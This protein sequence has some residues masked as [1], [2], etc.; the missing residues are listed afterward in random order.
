MEKKDSILFLSDKWI[1]FARAFFTIRV[2][3]YMVTLASLPQAPRLQLWFMILIE[4]VQLSL[5]IRNIFEHG[6]TS[7]WL[8]LIG[9]LIGISLF[10]SL[11][12][13]ALVMIGIQ[14]RIKNST[15]MLQKNGYYLILTIFTVEATLLVLSLIFSGIKQI[16]KKKSKKGEKKDLASKKNKT[17]KKNEDLVY[18]WVQT[19][20]LKNF[21]DEQVL[22]LPIQANPKARANSGSIMKMTRAEIHSNRMIEKKD[23]KYQYLSS[24]E[25]YEYSK[26]KVR[27]LS[28][29]SINSS[30]F[31]VLDIKH[32]RRKREKEDNLDEYLRQIYF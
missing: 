2:F 27:E 20:A 15:L 28:R 8:Y 14:T 6:R 7:T 22:D 5:V 31:R 16:F 13:V 21:L 12:I 32:N 9:K 25:K 3:L 4:F 24:S 10:M 17:E 23:S 29:E 19:L 11:E 1:L 18:R 26:Q 30:K